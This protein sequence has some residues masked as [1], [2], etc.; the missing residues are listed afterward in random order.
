[1]RSGSRAASS[2]GLVLGAGQAVSTSNGCEILLP[3]DPARAMAL[4]NFTDYLPDDILAKVDRASMAV[5][6][7]VRSPL[8]DRR[9][10]EFAWSLPTSF[11]LGAADNKRILRDVLARYMPSTLIK[12]RKRGFGMPIDSWL[13]GPLR[14]WA[15]DLLKDPDFA[16]Q[17]LFD[18]R[19]VDRLWRQH[20]ARWADH[21]NLLWAILMF[22]S[23]WHAHRE[24]LR[25]VR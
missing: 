6:L 19:K 4:A 7:E 8:L 10:I 11:L 24:A 1:V 23:W 18:S 20:L 17:G 16:T 2:S 22:Q 12:R 15:T 5:G 3:Q 9:V 13:R 25:H 14:S 21:G